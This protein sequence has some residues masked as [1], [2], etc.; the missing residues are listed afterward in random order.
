MLK[1]VK[2]W[3]EAVDAP[4]VKGRIYG[5]PQSL[6]SKAVVGFRFESGGEKALALQKRP[7]KM[8]KIGKAIYLVFLLW[9]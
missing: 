2:G 3:T 9:I 8:E 1:D 4:F 7:K 6:V 5:K